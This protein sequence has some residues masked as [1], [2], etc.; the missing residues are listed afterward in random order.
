MAYANKFNKIVLNTSNKSELATGYGTL[1]GDMIGGL[2][3][4]GDLYKTQVYELA[5]YINTNTTVI[6]LSIIEKAP[7]AE[8]RPNQKDSDSLP[9]YEILDA[10]LFQLIEEQASVEQVIKN[11]FDEKLVKRT[12]QLLTQNEYKR[13]QFCPILRVSSKSF[14]SGRRIPIVAKLY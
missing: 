3:I 6:P 13:N 9:E 12:A 8:L 2:S 10:V 4:L 1:Y 5:H 11:G 14:G 7:S